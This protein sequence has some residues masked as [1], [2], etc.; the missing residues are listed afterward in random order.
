MFSLAMLGSSGISSSG[1]TVR[2][3]RSKRVNFSRGVME[4]LH[5]LCMFEMCEVLVPWGRVHENE[6]KQRT[7]VKL[8]ADDSV[9]CFVSVVKKPTYNWGFCPES[10]SKLRSGMLFFK[11]REMKKQKDTGDWTHRN[12]KSTSIDCQPVNREKPLQFSLWKKTY[13]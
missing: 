13:L 5:G 7:I 6:R 8:T 3:P 9:N 10:H 4:A 1:Q 11:D 2:K 12:T